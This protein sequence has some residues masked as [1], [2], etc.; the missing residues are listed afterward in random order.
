M[1]LSSPVGST[2]RRLDSPERQ[3]QQCP[4]RQGGPRVMES[5]TI[6]NHLDRYLLFHRC[7]MKVR[8]ES[9]RPF[10]LRRHRRHCHYCCNCYYLDRSRATFLTSTPAILQQCSKTC[11]TACRLTFVMP[12]AS[13]PVS[14]DLSHK[15]LCSSDRV[16]VVACSKGS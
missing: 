14:D 15:V 12:D 5:L 8:L 2:C 6:D 3:P 13:K 10:S 4:F 7:L 11:S 1:K 16:R 9:R